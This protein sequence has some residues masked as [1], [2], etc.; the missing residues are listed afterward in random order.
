MEERESRMCENEDEMYIAEEKSEFGPCVR[1]HIRLRVWVE[2]VEWR[3]MLM[4]DG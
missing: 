3:L 2:W 1:T 4:G